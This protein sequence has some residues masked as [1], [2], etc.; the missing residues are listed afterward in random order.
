MIG[1]LLP[2]SVYLF[3]IATG[4]FLNLAIV[5]V[6]AESEPPV[7]ITYTY[8]HELLP[9]Q[10][11]TPFLTIYSN[12]SMRAVFPS[13]MKLSGVRNAQL[14]PSALHDLITLISADTMQGLN[15]E[16]IAEEIT[17]RQAQQE[18][19]GN[20]G[21]TMHATMDST[22]TIIKYQQVQSNSTTNIALKDVT[23]MASQFPEIVNLQKIKGLK[24]TL[25]NIL[26]TSEWVSTGGNL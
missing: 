15:T 4:I 11:S 14:S 12:G 6:K 19:I 10:G 18:Q 22:T 5:P 23:S 17:L 25:Q 13:N 20:A 24:N 21:G 16:T 9:K 3:L 8:E 1:K 26:D 2:N 7:L